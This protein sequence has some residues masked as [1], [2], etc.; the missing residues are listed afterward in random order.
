MDGGRR[1]E[2]APRALIAGTGSG[3]GKTT[4][5]CAVLQALVDRG[6]DVA[7]FK[8]GPDYID[9]MF[10][11]E[12]I[13]ARS[14]NIDLYFSDEALARGLFLKHAAAL[15][16]IEGVMG[17]YDGLSTDTAEASSW[18]VAR[19]L[20]APA[21]LVVSGR[22]MA[23]SAAAVVRGF[24]AMRAPSAIRGVVLNRVSPAIY[25]RLREAIEG[26]TGVRVFG[27]LPEMDACRLE[28]RRLGLVTARE[29]EDLRQKTRLLA[30]QA[31]R[32]VDLD[33]LI[34]LMRAQPPLEAALPGETKLADVRV[35]VARDRAFCFYY[36]DNLDLLEELGAKLIAFSPLDDARLPDCDG[37]YLGGGYPELYAE[38]LSRNRTMLDSIRDAVAGGLP[39]VAACGGFMLL[40]DRIGECPM[41]GVIRA[42]CRDAKRLTRFGYVELSAETDSLLFERGDAV[43]GHEFHYWDA[44]DPG[45]ALAARKPSGRA[46]RCAHVSETLYAGFPHLYFPGAPKAARRFIEKCQE[47]KMR[48]EA[49]GDRGAQL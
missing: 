22:G 14:A 7:A 33:A 12:I 15:N 38:R 35:A 43:R 39:T 44:T 40:T 17:Y 28:S 25:P 27:Y 11:S 9:P 48:R 41:A 24:Q 26:E 46:W 21:I 45:A 34:D 20:D 8:C 1:I 18:H 23:L 29:V 32:S 31:E 2:A 5:V 42:D 47:R 4:V 16:V 3:C 10:H 19:A 13:G 37:L 36:R 30:E 49:A 6:C